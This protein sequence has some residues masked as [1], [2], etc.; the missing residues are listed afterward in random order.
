[1]ERA[2]FSGKSGD[3]SPLQSCVQVNTLCRGNPHSANP[4]EKGRAATRIGKI[5][6]T[7]VARGRELKNSSGIWE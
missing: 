3:A 7:G 2:N 5:C 1:M 6:Y 4:E